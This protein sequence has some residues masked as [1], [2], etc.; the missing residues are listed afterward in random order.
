MS[1]ALKLEPWSWVDICA[2]D[3]LVPN[4][5]VAAL[6]GGRQIALFRVVAGDS[7]P[8]TVYAIDNRDLKSGA[9][10]LS[11]G[12]VGDIGG[13]LVVASPIYKQHYSL[14]S[15]R[16]IEHPE[17]S[18]GTYP[19]RVLDGQVQVGLS[20]S[21][22]RRAA[23]SPRQKLVVIGDGVAGR[24][25]VNELL[26]IAPDLYDIT[27]LGA[28]DPVVG[29]QRFKRIVRTSSGRE[30]AYDRLLLATGAAPVQSP[31]PA[32]SAPTTIAFTDVQEIDALL[33]AARG[34]TSAIVVG[35]GLLAL[36]AANGLLRQG[37][38][39]TIALPGDRLMPGELDA[40]A[41]GLLRA[42]LEKRGVTF[43]RDAVGSGELI[44][45][46][47]GIRPNIALAAKIGLRCEHGVLVSDTLQTFDPRIYAV[48]ACVQHRNA[49]FGLA[50][51]LEQQIR[52]CASH[53]AELGHSRYRSALAARKL[54]I[55]GIE[56]CSAGDIVGGD[57]SEDLVYR[58]TRRGVYKRLV[59]KDSRVIGAVL[60]GDVRDANWYFDLIRNR[61]DVCAQRD[62]LLFGPDAS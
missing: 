42:S 2:L 14:R 45:M 54:S 3:D 32:T 5:G 51:P 9:N 15:G 22:L 26:E 43:V 31:M 24:G 44:V 11:R 41:A 53:L 37:L 20:S 8:G 46:A 57:G 30:L 33:E 62:R 1:A 25:V 52:V 56:A 12:I 23:K 47:A 48:G 40:H 16:C 59:V 21:Y 39:V 4:V 38:R 7:D 61:T 58:D 35:G 29:V 10:V 27:L 13:E 60:Y 28:A 17:H 6:A 55:S 18:V 49:T 19:V 34:H 36:E 50:T